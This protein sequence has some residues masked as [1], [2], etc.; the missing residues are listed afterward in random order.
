MKVTL[1]NAYVI[2]EADLQPG[3]GYSY[4]TIFG[5]H[6]NGY[7][8]AMPQMN[9]ACEMAEPSDL[10]YNRSSLVDHGIAEETADK[11]AKLIKLTYIEVMKGDAKEC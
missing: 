11:L 2:F 10:F 7:F 1:F 9:I 4:L 3:N 5:R 6:A 8:C